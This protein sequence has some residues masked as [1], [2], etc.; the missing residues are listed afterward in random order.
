M[1]NSSPKIMLGMLINVMLIKKLYWEQYALVIARPM[2]RVW[3]NLIKKFKQNVCI[4]WRNQI[5]VI[6][7]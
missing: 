6:L 2:M 5:F 1:L 3:A 7:A 4:W